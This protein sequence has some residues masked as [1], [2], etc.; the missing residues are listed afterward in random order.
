MIESIRSANLLSLVRVGIK[1]NI[2]RRKQSSNRLAP[3]LP[4]TALDFHLRLF[5]S[6]EKDE[7]SCE[8]AVHLS[9]SFDAEYLRVLDPVFDLTAPSA[10][11][12]PPPNVPLQLCVF[13]PER[14]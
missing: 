12:L 14:Q 9:I 3:T 13:A 5:A 11:I 7:K 10:Q 4:T 8:Y 6:D 1:R 2:Q